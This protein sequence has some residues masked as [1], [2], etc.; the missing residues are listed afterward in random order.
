MPGYRY[1]PE[2]LRCSEC[3]GADFGSVGVIHHLAGCSQDPDGEPGQTAMPL[4]RR[5]PAPVRR[6]DRASPSALARLRALRT[7]AR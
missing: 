2:W 4:E 1:H 7:V 3:G 6:R 5:K